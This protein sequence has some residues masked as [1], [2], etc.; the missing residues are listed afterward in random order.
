M[1]EL[2]DDSNRNGLQN[3]YLSDQMQ[4]AG[5]SR[6]SSRRSTDV[7]TATGYSTSSSAS[8][9]TQLLRDY[10]I[11]FWDPE[12]CIKLRKRCASSNETSLAF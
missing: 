7:E 9:F 4:A 1:E 5:S 2:P 6:P 8:T 10:T 11:R 3:Q 12:V